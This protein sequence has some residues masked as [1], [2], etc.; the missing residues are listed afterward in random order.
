MGINNKIDIDNAQKELK[1]T[2]DTLYQ[3]FNGEVTGKYA[4]MLI[5]ITCK[6]MQEQSKILKSFAYEGADSNTAITSDIKGLI[7]ACRKYKELYN[8]YLKAIF[9]PKYI[10]KALTLIKETQGKVNDQTIDIILKTADFFEQQTIDIKLSELR[11]TKKLI[12][13][14]LTDKAH[15]FDQ[16]I[17]VFYEKTAKEAKLWFA[18]NFEMI[19][20][21]NCESFLNHIRREIKDFPYQYSDI[22]EDDKT[23]LK[24]SN[25]IF[26]SMIEINI[27]I[28]SFLKYCSPA[29]KCCTTS[30]KGYLPADLNTDRA[31][32]YFPKAI[33]AGII[34]QE[35]EKYHKKNISKA[36][37]A[38]FL[39]LVFCR[40]NDGKYNHKNFP[41]KQ[42][43]NLFEESRLGQTL[44]QCIGN[45]NTNGKPKGYETIDELFK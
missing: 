39:D 8:L 9:L 27:A 5:E 17:H 23:I 11:E 22:T 14:R 7:D 43:S 4:N 37:L 28:E 29:I 6:A 45:K 44:R 32:K 35:G 1:F 10:S 19:Y 38:Y 13:F 41:D 15:T 25:K 36:L 26:L 34:V 42:L 12:E 16:S 3:L 24:D 40:N 30:T 33:E 20:Y 31:Q 18:N 21:Q 2:T